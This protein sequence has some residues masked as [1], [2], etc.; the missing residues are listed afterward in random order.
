MFD[1]PISRRKLPTGNAVEDRFQDLLSVDVSYLTG[2]RVQKK[3][4]RS[5]ELELYYGALQEDLINDDPLMQDPFRWWMERGK[6]EYPT[7]YKMALDFFSIPSTSCE[8]ERAFSGGRRTVTFERGSLHGATIEAL[9]LQKNWLKNR[10]VTSELRK[11]MDYIEKFP[12]PKEEV[13]PEIIEL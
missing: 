13:E 8:C 9:Q 10:V 2:A 3:A 5:N 1:L 7:L 11:L 4:R 12:P 6:K